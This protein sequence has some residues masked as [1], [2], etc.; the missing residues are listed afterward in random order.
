MNRSDLFD[1]IFYSIRVTGKN[2]TSLSEIQKYITETIASSEEKRIPLNFTLYGHHDLNFNYPV[3]L[4]LYNN[5][6]DI[7]YQYHLERDIDVLVIDDHH[8]VKD[9]QSLLNLRGFKVL[10]ISDIQIILR[11]M[12]V[13][14]YLTP[15]NR[16]IIMNPSE[17][18][19]RNVVAVMEILVS[20]L[21]KSF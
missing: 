9:F 18:L 12:G 14:G 4:S 1:S 21:N 2:W 8:I 3:T 20:F 19:V 10:N 11:D 17:Y 15:D 7:T 13:K 6:D 16:L 5:N